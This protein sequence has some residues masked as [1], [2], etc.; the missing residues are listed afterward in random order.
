MRT[1]ALALAATCL[2]LAAH[3][4]PAPLPKP[5]S[6]K[7]EKPDL[8]RM[9]GTW[10][11]VGNPATHLVVAGDRWTFWHKGR[12]S[13]QYRCTLDPK[14]E[15]KHLHLKGVGK[16]AGRSWLGIYR[17]NGDS[18]KFACHPSVRPQ[19]FGPSSRDVE[20]YVYKRAKKR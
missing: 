1:T 19:D 5:D 20:R 16:T 18:L 8:K 6:K 11:Q 10:E 9:K 4:A 7:P 14:Q 13:A 2:A 17:L 15:P 12:L 3:A